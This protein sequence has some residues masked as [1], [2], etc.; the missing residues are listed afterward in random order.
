VSVAEAAGFSFGEEAAM[1]EGRLVRLRPAELADAERFSRW[2][3]DQEVT[4]FLIADRYP[5]SLA[6]EE[7]FVRERPP[8]SFSDGAIFAVETKDGRHIGWTSFYDV[9]TEDRKACLAVTIGEKECW[10]QGYGGD[11]VVTLLR[12]GFHEMGLNRVWLTTVEY[13]ERA[14]ACY[15]RCGFVEEVRLRQDAYRHG[16]YWDF[17]QMGILRHEFDEQHEGGHHA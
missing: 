14:I 6:E 11:A 8:M 13:N 2:F 9:H 4:R 12:F 3:N 16:R 15:K 5:V 7:R 17:V 1:I 10:S